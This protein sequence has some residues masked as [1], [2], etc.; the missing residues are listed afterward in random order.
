M[1]PLEEV[2]VV[3]EVA[4]TELAVVVASVVLQLVVRQEHNSTS[5]M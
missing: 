5:A 1:E 2:S 3:V 4:S